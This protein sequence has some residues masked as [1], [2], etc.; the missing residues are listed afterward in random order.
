M[1]TISPLTLIDKQIKASLQFPILTLPDP[2]RSGNKSQKNLKTN[3][4]KNKITNKTDKIN[5]DV[6]DYDGFFNRTTQRQ[7]LL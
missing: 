4:P 1:I 7:M 3:N 2:S 5:T 6:L